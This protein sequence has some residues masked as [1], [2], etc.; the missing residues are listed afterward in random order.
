VGGTLA[1]I[2]TAIESDKLITKS[3]DYQEIS[4]AKT[5]TLTMENSCVKKRKNTDGSSILWI[6]IHTLVEYS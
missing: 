2:I 1:M 4:L 5:V 3:G 6:R